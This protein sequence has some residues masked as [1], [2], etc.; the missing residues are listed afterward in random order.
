M[1][2]SGWRPGGDNTLWSIEASEE[3]GYYVLVN[4]FSGKALALDPSYFTQRVEKSY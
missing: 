3:A 4:K 2:I 1:C